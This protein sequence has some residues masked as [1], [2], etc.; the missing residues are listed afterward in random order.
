MAGYY[1]YSMSNNAV[2]AYKKGLLPASKIPGVPASLVKP[3]CQPTE[4]HHTSSKYNRTDFYNP[5]EVRAIFG[6]QSHGNIKANPAAVA[7]LDQ[8]KAGPTT[9]TYA[10]CR[11]Q[12]IEWAGTA[13]KP[14]RTTM[15]AD[16][17]TV[18][19]KGQTA[20]VTLPSGKTIVKRMFT[21]GFAFHGSKTTIIKTRE[22]REKRSVSQPLF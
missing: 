3:F 19:V 8:Y 10:N 16:N 5:D 13:K 1:N 7:A 21:K 12:W 4:W 11:V 14:T 9:E 15:T 6:L 2:L 22:A 18:E 17:C 20:T